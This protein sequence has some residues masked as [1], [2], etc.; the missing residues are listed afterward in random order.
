MPPRHSSEDQKETDRR[1]RA[2]T[3]TSRINSHLRWGLSTD[4]PRPGYVLA[5]ATHPP[6]VCF[7]SRNELHAQF[8]RSH[9]QLC[10]V[11]NQRVH[12]HMTGEEQQQQRQ[13]YYDSPHFDGFMTDSDAKQASI[14]YR[15][16][17]EAG[18]QVV[19]PDPGIV[20]LVRAQREIM[21][22]AR[23][24]KRE[25]QREENGGQSPDDDD[26]NTNNDEKDRAEDEAE[27]RRYMQQYRFQHSRAGS[28]VVE[29]EREGQATGVTEQQEAGNT[30]DT[31]DTGAGSES[32]TGAVETGVTDTSTDRTRVNTS[33]V[34]QIDPSGEAED[35]NVTQ[36]ALE[37]KYRAEVERNRAA[38][39]E[40]RRTSFQNRVRNIST[41]RR[42]QVPQQQQQEV[43]VE[44][45]NQRREQHTPPPQQR[46][47]S[48]SVPPERRQAD[49][50]P[51]NARQQVRAGGGGG[52]GGESPPSSPS[53]DDNHQH[54]ADIERA[55]RNRRRQRRADDAA[56]NAPA[57]SLAIGNIRVLIPRGLPADYYVRS[58]KPDGMTFKLIMGIVK[59]LDDLIWSTKLMAQEWINSIQNAIEVTPVD[60]T[61][62]IFI[63]PQLIPHT[64]L[65]R[66]THDYVK[67]NII[68]PLLPWIEAKLLFINHFARADWADSRRLAL[69]QCKQRKDESVQHYS[70]RFTAISNEVGLDDTDK[71][72]IHNY[73]Q[74][75]KSEVHM[76]LNRHRTM[77]RVQ[78]HM[79][80]E[81]P[82]LSEV[83]GLAIT[84]DVSIKSA[85]AIAKRSSTDEISTSK[86]KKRKGNQEEKSGSKKKKV[87]GGTSGGKTGTWCSFHKVTTHNTSDCRGK[88]TTPT[89]TSPSV[90][91][92]SSK[93]GSKK[94]KPKQKP[95]QDTSDVTCYTCN[96]KGHYANKCPEK[97]K[98]ARGSSVSFQD[99]EGEED[100][101]SPPASSTSIQPGKGKWLKP[102]I[103]R[104]A[105]ARK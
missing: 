72:N 67:T 6:N 44:Q 89:S 1:L 96:K 73:M 63:L 66:Q 17:I 56:A 81:F 28:A 14:D 3:R 105:L 9:M 82:S 13:L 2:I 86:D 77:Q 54:V 26:E 95:N 37:Q 80:Y 21:R 61:H 33:G 104:A 93:P 25:A 45:P 5:P 57:P 71:L 99:E 23:A 38:R 52:G 90:S 10:P 15:R 27:I 98:K 79:A 30:G 12:L 29:G 68:D 36:E 49:P 78:H 88:G 53:S 74:G 20:Q 103:K 11:C 60:A 101:S 39:E 19:G 65:Y 92:S 16:R 7:L 84:Y 69:E 59:N 76:E 55:H 102:S 40:S 75:L 51:N 91:A 34:E 35:D 43:D 87:K 8:G 32:E 100:A 18:E 83:V 94:P 64:S 62:W 70:D 48:S 22:Q 85:N 97:D 41:G 31:Q 24:L 4:P 42:V 50:P 58:V 46:E 47:R